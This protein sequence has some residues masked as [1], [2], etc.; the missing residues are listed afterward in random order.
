MQKKRHGR[1]E[2]L[3]EKWKHNYK[4]HRELNRRIKEVGHDILSSPNFRSTKQHIQHG[5]ITVN[6]H[7]LSVARYSLALSR[8]LGV[9]C[10]EDEL[11]RGALLHDYFLY[12]WHEKDEINPHRLHG[13]Y[14]P[15]RALGN[16]S[17]EY[18]LTPI[19]MEIIRKHMWPLTPVPPMCREAWIVTMA[20]KW[21]SLMETLHIHKGHGATVV[22]SEK[23]K[24]EKKEK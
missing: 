20:D 23:P 11:I 2:R 1:S 15:G 17:K 13:F 8:K 5:N 6:A 19:E 3:A 21:C 16:A 9:V 10:S 24:Q 4:K 14:H 22:E 12:D 18:E 7:C